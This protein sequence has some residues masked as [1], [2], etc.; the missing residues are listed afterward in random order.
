MSVCI[1]Y[2]TSGP[3][4]HFTTPKHIFPAGIGD[5]RTLEAGYCRGH[6]KGEFTYAKDYNSF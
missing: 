5:G 2:K 4:I 1:Y 6:N 3:G